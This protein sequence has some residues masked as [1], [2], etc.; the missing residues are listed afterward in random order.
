MAVIPD[1]PT[2]SRSQKCNL[3]SGNKQ[4]F[5]DQENEKPGAIK[6][7]SEALEAISYNSHGLVPVIAQCA[8]TQQVLMM[9]WMNKAALEETLKTGRLCYWS[10]S[11][12][13]LWRKGESSG[14]QQKLVSLHIDCDGDTLLAKVQ[15]TGPACHTNRQNCF[16]WAVDPKAGK[17]ILKESFK[18]K[19]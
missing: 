5:K 12:Q 7:L 11:R 8:R 16:F 4:W 10:R 3:E 13:Q 18:E 6:P 17:I 19:K 2:G 14:H 1:A 9:A 15:Q